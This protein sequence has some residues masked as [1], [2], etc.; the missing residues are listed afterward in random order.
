[1]TH[2]MDDELMQSLSAPAARCPLVN[3]Q[4]GERH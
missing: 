1:M 2:A 3:A 4:S